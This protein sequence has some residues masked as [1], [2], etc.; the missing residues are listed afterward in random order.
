MTKSSVGEH[1]IVAPTTHVGGEDEHLRPEA[2][3]D[4]GDQL[5]PGERRR[6][7]ADLVGAGSQQPIDVATARTPPPT[8]SGMKTCS[9]CGG[10]R[11]RSS[12]DRRCSR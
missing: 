5:G 4:L 12:R 6:V 2:V 10:R 11:R 3:G 1:V 8:V 9:A 7:D